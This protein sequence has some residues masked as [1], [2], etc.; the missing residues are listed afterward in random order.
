MTATP[1]RTAKR[2]VTASMF[3]KYASC[4]HWLW[5]DAFGDPAKK[6]ERSEF[7]EK[8]IQNGIE[9]EEDV[10]KDMAFEEVG[11]DL[12]REERFARTVELMKEGVDRI[13]HGLLINGDMLGEPDLLERRN[14]KP[15]EFG[16]YHYVP[17]DIKSAEK[18]SDGHKYQLTFYAELLKAVQGRRPTEAYILN[19][20]RVVI[21]FPIA[22][23]EQ[24]YHAALREVRAILAGEKPA[25]HVS[26]G[27]KASPWFGEC[28]AYAEEKHDI[29]LLYNVRKKTL[30][31][32]REQGV[33]T[34]EDAADMNVDA[35]FATG[36]FTKKTLD[37]II[38]QAEALRSGRHHFRSQIAFPEAK[39]EYFFDIEGD[40]FRELEYLFGFLV[41]D[42]AG[43]RYVPFTAER[44]EDEE[45]M[46]KEF[47]AWLD[48]M[49]PEYAVYHYGNYEQVRCSHLERKYGGSAALT[50]FME[51]LVDLNELIK[52][53]VVFPLY[54]YSIKD[55]GKYIHYKREGEISGGGE[56]IWYYEQWLETGDREKL[57]AVLL[58]NKD[59]VV[60]TRVLKDWLARESGEQEVGS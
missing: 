50:R 40:P 30:D 39:H 54:F 6:G 18:L 41:R 45:N 51:N 9:H 20:S 1:K 33:R 48:G 16:Q 53:N 35:L 10:I 14:D 24:R 34:I 32:L 3:T 44:P 12:S 17:I 7:A 60:A 38:L 36:E 5:F 19:A 57:D 13:Y 31:A 49:P 59:D 42:P 47:L 56:S 46:W 43:E 22:E 55:I 15:S 27:C 37:R 2:Y 4:P 11:K 58:Y 25:P 26:S 21:G 23:F 52:K 28:V 8:L 29:A